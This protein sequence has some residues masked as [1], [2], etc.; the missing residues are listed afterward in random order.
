MGHARCLLGLL[1]FGNT[2]PSSCPI[3]VLTLAAAIPA[4][5]PQLPSIR[6]GSA[7]AG[8]GVPGPGS[9]WAISAPP[10]FLFAC[11]SHGT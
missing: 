2:T 6:K 3:S 7:R 4:I 8:R 11:S 1:E 5:N 9:Q 10:N